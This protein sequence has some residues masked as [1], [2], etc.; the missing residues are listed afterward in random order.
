MT[1][2]R[3]INVFYR[4]D[5]TCIYDKN[6]D[7]EASNHSTNAKESVS[8]SGSELWPL[9]QVFVQFAREVQGGPVR[10]LVFRNPHEYAPTVQR[11]EASPQYSDAT[12]KRPFVVHVAHDEL[13]A[14][15]V[16]ETLRNEPGL[17]GMEDEEN[18]AG[19][20]VAEF[21]ELILDH[22]VKEQ[23]AFL[24][25][26][27]PKDVSPRPDGLLPNSYR[28]ENFQDSETDA[29]T[30]TTS[31]QEYTTRASS[32]EWGESVMAS[33]LDSS[34]MDM[35]QPLTTADRNPIVKIS[36]GKLSEFIDKTQH[37]MRI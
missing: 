29:A 3:R 33:G 20:P 11:F 23:T 24:A 30:G 17:D 7:D 10:R 13:F 4:S 12:G 15:T 35:D 18:A 27:S 21:C 34:L 25:T 36:E 32:S 26:I 14:V 6:W 19:V 31:V 8:I 2:S 22:L 1:A 16:C 9:V 28:A 5:G 37:N